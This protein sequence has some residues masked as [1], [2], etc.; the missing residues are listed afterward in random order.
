M[1]G[2]EIT[3]A[4]YAC[5]RDSM[6]GCS[7]DYIPVL[8]RG[9]VAM[10]KIKLSVCRDTLEHRVLD[11]KPDLIPAHMGNFEGDAVS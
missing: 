11:F 2:K 1:D 3:P 4:Q 7:N 10:N 5:K 8:R 9:I 6:V